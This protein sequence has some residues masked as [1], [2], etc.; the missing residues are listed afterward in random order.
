M[1]RRIWQAAFLYALI[2][3]VGCGNDSVAY[4]PDPTLPVAVNNLG[5]LIAQKQRD[6][7]KPGGDVY[8]PRFSAADQSQFDSSN[9]LQQ[10]VSDV[11]RS[12]TFTSGVAALKTLSTTKQQQVLTNFAQPEDPTWAQTGQI[13]DGTTD[14]GQMVEIEIATALT[15][16]VKTALAQ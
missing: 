13:G 1:L 15:N 6:V 5:R 9:R 16:A 11:T 2:L 4:T 14:A 10:I 3:I 12:S 8:N 7:V